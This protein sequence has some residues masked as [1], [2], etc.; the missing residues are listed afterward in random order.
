MNDADVQLGEKIACKKQFRALVSDELSV[1]PLDADVVTSSLDNNAPDEAEQELP[2]NVKPVAA[3]V[4]LL[5]RQDGTM[6]GGWE[7]KLKNDE[8]LRI[9]SIHDRDATGRTRIRCS[10]VRESR[11][12]SH[13]RIV[14]LRDIERLVLS[15]MLSA[16]RSF[17]RPTIIVGHAWGSGG[18]F[19]RFPS[20]SKTLHRHPEGKRKAA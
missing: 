1:T 13:R 15:G 10:A 5:A 12:C 7:D 9:A 16:G 18:R 8:Q 2:K 14:Y 19:T 6:K 11:S 4:Q 20:P 17:R 3:K